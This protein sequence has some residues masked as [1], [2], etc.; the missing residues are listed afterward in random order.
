MKQLAVVAESFWNSRASRN[1]EQILAIVVVDGI[2]Y[3]VTVRDEPEFGFLYK[4]YG[5]DRI[6]DRLVLFKSEKLSDIKKFAQDHLKSKFD[7]T[8]N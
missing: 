4:F 7:K 1:M 2:D 8:Q 6:F 5:A 3:L